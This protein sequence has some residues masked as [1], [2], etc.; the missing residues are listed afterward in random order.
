MG[1][2]ETLLCRYHHNNFYSDLSLEHYCCFSLGQADAM[3]NILRD[4]PRSSSL[5]ILGLTLIFRRAYKKTCKTIELVKALYGTSCVF[6]EQC[7]QMR[8]RR[9]L[10]PPVL[11]D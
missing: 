3:A 10:D 7:L 1:L 2:A 4:G 8:S 6:R 5:L 9:R 11:F